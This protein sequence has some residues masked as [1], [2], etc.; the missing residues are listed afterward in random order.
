MLYMCTTKGYDASIAKAPRFES[1]HERILFCDFD[2][3]QNMGW[4]IRSSV[5]IDVHRSDLINRYHKF[6]AHRILSGC[7]ISIYVDGNILLY[8]DPAEL[9]K[10]FISSDAPIGFA[11]HPERRQIT[12]ELAACIE[13]GK[14][15]MGDEK[16]AQEQVHKYL[17]DERYPDNNNLFYGGVIFRNHR[18]KEALDQAMEMWWREVQEYSARDQISLPYVIWKTGLKV[19]DLNFNIKNN[20]YFFRYSHKRQ[21]S[22]TKLNLRIM[23]NSIKRFLGISK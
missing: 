7:D 17:V 2:A 5:R 10:E 3:P 15:K 14:F 13:L 4:T 18:Y 6:F 19:Y 8:A 12:D 9:I 21:L 23:E 11:K 16:R 1:L 20:P 22:R